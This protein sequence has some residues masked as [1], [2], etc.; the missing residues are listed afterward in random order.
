MTLTTNQASAMHSLIKS[1]CANM[2]GKDLADL[3]CDP[4]VWVDAN[5]LVNAGWGRKEA[6]G[7]FGSLVAAGLIYHYEDELFALTEDWDELRK[8]HA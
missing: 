6:E 4:F 1:C 7:T 3:E 5:D 2:G 8:F